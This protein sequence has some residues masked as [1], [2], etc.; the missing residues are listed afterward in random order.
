[1]AG[2][3]SSVQ[4][5]GHRDAG[6]LRALEELRSTADNDFTIIKISEP[7]TSTESKTGGDSDA[8]GAART[9]DVSSA[10]LDAPTPASLDADLAHYKELFS[11]LRFSYVEQVTKEKFIRAIVGDPP[12]IVTP[13][14]IADLEASNAAA[15]A[16]LK[17]LKTEVNGMV[18]DLAARGRDLAL[19]YERVR[20][21]TAA[22]AE[23]PGKIEALEAQ[24][25]A[26]RAAQ[27]AGGPDAGPDM[28]LPLGKTLAL[29]DDK[30][31]ELA[32]L[33]RQLERLGTQVPCKRKELERLRTEVANLETKKA[34]STAAARDAKRRRENAQDRVEDELEA[35][36]R[37]YR[38][39]ENV[40]REVLDLQLG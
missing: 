5:D 30:K 1:M 25:A 32:A 40:L 34:N 18:S 3:T 6:V 29:A 35:K 26:L 15:K 20:T 36:G 16:T 39:S 22:L 2:A 11:K 17:S 21:D 10:S 28:R 37:W 9:S 23:L 31:R 4:T 14:E 27:Q 12:L 7:I 19:R 38:A 13:Q 33:D 24:V 8:A